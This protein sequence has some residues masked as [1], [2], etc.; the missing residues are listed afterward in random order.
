MCETLCAIG[1]QKKKPNR[2]EFKICVF[3]SSLAHGQTKAKDCGLE[4]ARE[5]ER[6]RE[7]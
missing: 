3:Y 1:S 5:R 7:K 6:L 4:R 2:I